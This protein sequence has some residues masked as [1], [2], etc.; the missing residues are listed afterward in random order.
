MV[1]SSPKGREIAHNALRQE[2]ICSTT[3]SLSKYPSQFLPPPLRWS[4]KPELK[5]APSW[6]G[7]WCGGTRVSGE[8]GDERRRL[9]VLR[10]GVVL[11]ETRGET[12]SSWQGVELEVRESE[13]EF[14][15]VSK[16]FVTL[17]L[18]ACSRWR[19]VGG[20]SRVW[21]SNRIPLVQGCPPLKGNQIGIIH[22]WGDQNNLGFAIT[23]CDSNQISLSGICKALKVS[24]L[25]SSGN[26]VVLKVFYRNFIH[27]TIHGILKP[28]GFGNGVVQVMILDKNVSCRKHLC[29]FVFLFI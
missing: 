16:R 3:A 4:V 5:L 27:H 23:H 17:V 11:A 9:F 6:L 26:N 25:R 22:T 21:Q 29:F 20:K 19:S 7:E 15:S 2:W 28:W 24:L 12:W 1:D 8:G 13:A 10:P 14:V 18:E